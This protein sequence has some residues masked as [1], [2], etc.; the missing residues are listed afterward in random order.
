MYEKT[1]NLGG[2]WQKPLKLGPFFKLSAYLR[3][4]LNFL[5]PSARGP[6]VGGQGTVTV[7]WCNAATRQQG[8]RSAPKN[9]SAVARSCTRRNVAM[10]NYQ[11][12]VKETYLRII[13]NTIAGSKA[14]FE[15]MDGLSE[16]LTKSLDLLRERW[17]VR[18]EDH[19]FTDDPTATFRGTASR[20]T[21]ASRRAEAKA[22]AVEAA[23]AA[24]AT[25]AATAKANA[26]AAKAAAETQAAQVAAAVGAGASGVT[27]PSA[28]AL[29][30]GAP[31]AVG[32]A[33]GSLV[34]PVGVP[35]PSM[36]TVV[37][38]FTPPVAP[39]EQLVPGPG[40]APALIRVTPAISQLE[41]GPAPAPALPPPSAGGLI[42]V[43][44]VMA[45]VPAMV[46]PQS[47]GVFAPPPLPGTLPGT[48]PGTLP[49]MAGGALL[50]TPPAE[51]VGAMLL[52]TPPTDG[53][54]IQFPAG[55]LGAAGHLPTL[56]ADQ[57]V[58]GL[59]APP[60]APGNTEP[61]NAAGVASSA[62]SPGDIPQGD[63]ADA[64]GSGA[65]PPAKRARHEGEGGLEAVNNNED[66]G[67]D[68]SDDDEQKSDEDDNAENYILAQN[69][70]VKRTGSK[71]KVRLKDGIVHV[72]G[73]DYL[74][75]R[76]NCEFDWS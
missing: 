29:V 71:W 2:F 18:L 8:V 33:V 55:D 48:M 64:A 61:E 75:S 60:L 14:E 68:D 5:E 62:I 51:G 22:K 52:Q 40:S 56:P 53:A 43:T 12:N 10:G 34:A 9:C 73:R 15:E 32:G 16:G 58:S 65:P 42:R 54:G 36:G 74:F 47:M 31:A 39:R 41:A 21:V 26:A 45:P 72:N 46:A 66:L 59:P 7:L 67:S 49:G 69:E 44:P 27:G 38:G 23:S 35:V 1:H 11:A 25:A 63:G 3:F 70:S 50:E 28:S 20:G 57:G 76:A 19:D 4:G 13:E 30:P 6:T 17:Q 37:P 24:R